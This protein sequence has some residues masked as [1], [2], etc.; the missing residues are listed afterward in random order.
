MRPLVATSTRLRLRRAS[1]VAVLSRRDLIS[2]S[3]EEAGSS[4]SSLILNS[5]GA[6]RIR[7]FFGCSIS[8]GLE[9]MGCK[10]WG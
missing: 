5:R 3:D 4:P 6:A 2:S 10:N 8:K 9:G 7:V 1:S